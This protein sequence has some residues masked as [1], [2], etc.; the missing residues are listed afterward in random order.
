MRLL[1]MVV[2]G[3][4]S[5][6]K[7]QHSAPRRWQRCS[8]SHGT[9]IISEDAAWQHVRVQELRM[10]RY[11]FPNDELLPVNNSFSNTR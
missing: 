11:A 5:P 2:V 10:G 3:L 6:S 4:E 1:A 7:R 8:S 9:A